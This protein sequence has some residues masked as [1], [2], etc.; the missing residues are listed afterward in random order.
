M[1]RGILGDDG[2]TIWMLIACILFWGKITDWWGSA[3]NKLDDVVKTTSGVFQSETSDDLSLMQ[4][5]VNGWSVPWSTLPKKRIHY[6]EV[7]AT[8]WTEMKKTFVDEAKIIA[9]CTGLTAG[10]LKAVAKSFGVKKEKTFGLTVWE[11]H[12][13]AAFAQVCEDNIISDDLTQLRNIWK[14]SGIWPAN[15]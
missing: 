12:I 7:A 3:T 6:E 5:Q 11:G 2:P 8:L 13:F 1:A 4:K 9:I 10:E 15:I 14:K